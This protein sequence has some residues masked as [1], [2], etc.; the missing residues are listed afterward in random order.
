MAGAYAL[1]SMYSLLSCIYHLY[2]LCKMSPFASDLLQISN[3][4]W[5]APKKGFSLDFGELFGV[6]Y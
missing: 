4:P 5:T 6:S 2:S 1:L 3:L